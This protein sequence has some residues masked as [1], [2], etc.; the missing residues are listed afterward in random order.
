L[1]HLLDR[2]V[3]LEAMRQRIAD[4]AGSELAD[5][6][7]AVADREA[8]VAKL[9]RA[10]DATERA[11]DAGDIDAR[12]YAKREARLTAELAGATAALDQAQKAAESA[13]NGPVGG[14][15][16]QELLDHLAAL[17]AA[18]AD[19]VEHAPS[20]PALRNVLAELFDRVQL[21]KG[22]DLSPLSTYVGDG[23]A[24]L[25]DLP[26]AGDDLWLVP[27]LRGDSFDDECEPT[28]VE[29]PAPASALMVAKP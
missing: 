14:D 23:M 25:D 24:P 5:A 2:Y 13:S 16:E 19:G 11:M 28:P 10:I 18:V 20:L 12:Q 7:R 17:K 15:P 9:Q 26:A 4:R 27:I 29:L 1:R 8:E 3:D 22:D 6:R 21:V